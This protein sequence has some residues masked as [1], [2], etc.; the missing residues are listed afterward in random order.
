MRTSVR[1]N[2][3]VDP[4]LKALAKSVDIKLSH[5]LARGIH[6]L[7]KERKDELAKVLKELEDLTI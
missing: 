6:E 3:S 1:V 5:A 4:K 7:L 2:T